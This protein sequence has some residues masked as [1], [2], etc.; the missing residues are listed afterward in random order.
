MKPLR[1]CSSVIALLCSLLFAVNSAHASMYGVGDNGDNIPNIVLEAEYDFYGETGKLSKLRGLHLRPPYGL[2]V[3]TVAIVD[4]LNE[5]LKK[6][7]QIAPEVLITDRLQWGRFELFSVLKPLP[8]GQKIS[9]P[10]P[11]VCR[12]KYDCQVDRLFETKLTKEQRNLLSW[13]RYYLSKQ[14]RKRRLGNKQV[15]KVTSEYLLFSVFDDLAISTPAINFWLNLHRLNQDEV[16]LSANQA[17]NRTSRPEINAIANLVHALQQ[18]TE[19]ELDEQSFEFNMVMEQQLQ[20]LF[21]GQYS[22]PFTLFEETETGKVQYHRKDLSSIEFSQQLRSWQ[23]IKPLA[24]IKGE[25]TRYVIVRING[26]ERD[27]HVLPV[28]CHNKLCEKTNWELLRSKEIRLLNHPL[29]LKQFSRYFE[30]S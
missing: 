5:A 18:L 21:A 11:V 7:N 17:P 1:Q 12:S 28:A 22:Y 2:P 15:F 3:S 25:K 10:M 23:K 30:N 14:H 20:S 29:L 6:K 24:L 16:S 13:V 4:D 19:S 9:K 27:I 26:D 8:N